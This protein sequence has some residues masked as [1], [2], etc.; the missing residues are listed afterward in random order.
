MKICI[1]CGWEVEE[2][3]G[4]LKD[5]MNGYVCDFAGNTP[6]PHQTTLE[7]SFAFVA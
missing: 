1:K 5:K 3:A 2:E 4:L 6:L 7:R